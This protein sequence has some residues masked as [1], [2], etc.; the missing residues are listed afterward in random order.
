MPSHEIH[1]LKGRRENGPPVLINNLVESLQPLEIKLQTSSFIP[2]RVQL[3]LHLNFKEVAVSLC[4]ARQ[5]RQ[6][7]RLAGSANLIKFPPIGYTNY[8]CK[9]QLVFMEMLLIYYTIGWLLEA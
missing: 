5:E 4:G 8:P 1:I 2:R 3:I 7:P 6:R 9:P